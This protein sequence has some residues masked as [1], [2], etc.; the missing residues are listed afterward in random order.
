MNGKH[1]E[2]K[3]EGD[4]ICWS[5]ISNFGGPTMQLT[6][7]DADSK[8]FNPKLVS[9]IERITIEAEKKFKKCLLTHSAS[10]RK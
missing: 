1:A 9:A 4:K 7:V 10:Q 6:C 3:S 8:G 5:W 2:V